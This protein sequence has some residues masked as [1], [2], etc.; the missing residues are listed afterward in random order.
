MFPETNEFLDEATIKGK[1]STLAKGVQSRKVS[2]EYL[3]E[4]VAKS[5][6]VTGFS[7]TDVQKGII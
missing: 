6:A 7:N 1:L 4:A 5:E 3:A 2:K